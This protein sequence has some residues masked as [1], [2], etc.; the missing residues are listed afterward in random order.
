[1]NEQ[2]PILSPFRQRLL[3]RLGGE[4]ERFA[5]SFND[6]TMR[7]T[8]RRALRELEG[9]E[10][11]LEK[12][13]EAIE[14]AAARHPNAPR[15]LVDE[16]RSDFTDRLVN[17]WAA[18]Q[19][20]GAR[21]ANWMVVGPSNFPVRRNQKRIDTEDR[22]YQEL[23]ELV[24]RA[25]DRADKRLRRAVDQA[26]GPVG[27][28]DRELEEARAKLE[29]REKRQAFMKAANPIIRK[30]KALE[31]GAAIEAL[32]ADLKAA[33]LPHGPGLASSL[34]TPAWANGPVGFMPYQL[35]N[36]S[37][38][39]RRLRIRVAELER[40]AVAVEAAAAS[41]LEDPELEA[42]EGIKIVENVLE[43]RVQIF[44][45]DKP[46][47]EIR[48]RLKGRGFRWAPSQGAWQRQLTANAVDA[49]RAIVAA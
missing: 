29:Q 13:L 20:A 43:Q 24:D 39:I 26:L 40:R 44:F 6:R 14:K 35:S 17:A 23:R 27:I 15:E 30:H 47:A 7:C 8:R 33:G 3:A 12:G 22:R 9:G 5:S 45:P 48:A 1:M 16:I 2:T 38:E 11:E 46:D 36:N 19:H 42:G 28:A 10:L 41:E 18:H 49:A 32:C 4:L 21:T 37:A 34:L 31:R 25:G